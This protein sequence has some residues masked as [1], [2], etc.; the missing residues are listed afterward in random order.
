MS[1]RDELSELMQEELKKFTSGKYGSRKG[2][3]MEET[4]DQIDQEI[5]DRDIEKAKWSEK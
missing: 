3:T 2:K 5:K 4:I 1:E